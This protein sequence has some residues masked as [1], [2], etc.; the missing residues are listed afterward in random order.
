M[1][2]CHGRII[3]SPMHLWHNAPGIH[4]RTFLISMWLWHR[5]RAFFL[6]FI[7][8]SFV[9]HSTLLCHSPSTHHNALHVS[10][11]S[12]NTPQAPH[13]QIQPYS[14]CFADV[15]FDRLQ[16][17]AR[18]GVFR[19]LCTTTNACIH[20]HT[21]VHRL[22]RLWNLLLGRWHAMGDTLCALDAGKERWQEKH[23]CGRAVRYISHLRPPLRGINHAG[24]I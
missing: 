9:P 15:V 8:P 5:A 21:V 6:S 24:Y 11:C 18:A 13:G 10:M 12:N 22:L 23:V 19:F 4:C 1:F 7:P 3:I 2:Q 16:H 17:D 20:S 14:I